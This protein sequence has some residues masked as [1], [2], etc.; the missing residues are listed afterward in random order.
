MLMLWYLRLFLIFLILFVALFALNSEVSNWCSDQYHQVWDIHD[1]SYV[2]PESQ[3]QPGMSMKK[4]Y[5]NEDRGL[6]DMMMRTRLLFKRQNHI[7]TV[8]K[9]GFHADL[10][11]GT[12]WRGGKIVTGDDVKQQMEMAKQPLIQTTVTH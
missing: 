8:M 9:D 1:K 7:G 2:I 3:R 4:F 5:A 12:T 11:E 10:P 6:M